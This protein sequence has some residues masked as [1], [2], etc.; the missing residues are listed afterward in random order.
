MKSSILLIIVLSTFLVSCTTPL[1]TEQPVST[2]PIIPIQSTAL[3]KSTAIFKHPWLF[4]DTFD[5]GSLNTEWNV[6][7][8]QPQIRYGRLE[9]GNAKIILQI[10]DLYPNNFTIQFDINQ[11]GNDGYVQLTL[12]NQLQ[13]E[14]LSDLSTNQRLYQDN[15]WVEL[16]AGRI[17]RCAAHID[18]L[19]KSSSYIILNVHNDEVVQIL[20]GKNIKDINGPIILMMTPTASIDNFLI[21]SP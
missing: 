4:R 14:L 1:P 21:T 6:L 15:Q 18:I 16:P 7:E 9:T 5:S 10:D 3:P 13:F 19:I 20:E 12:G 11:C 17:H 2:F 8:G